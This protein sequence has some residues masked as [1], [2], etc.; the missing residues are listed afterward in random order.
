MTLSARLDDTI[1]RTR[2]LDHAYYRAWVAGELTEDD[3]RGYAKSYFAH[4]L[5]FPRYVSGVHSQCEDLDARRAL[6][7]NLVDEESGDEHH[8][9]LWLRF[10]EGLGESREAVEGC[11]DAATAK[12]IDTFL[13]RIRSSYAEGLGAL[14][15]YESQIPEIAETKV[16]SLSETY[17]ITDERTLAFFKVHAKADV[18]HSRTLREQIDGLTT[19]QGEQAEAAASECARGLWEFLSELERR[20]T[21]DEV[22][23]VPL[24]A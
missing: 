1:S 5:A 2:L 8:P 15:A 3:M 20:R 22:Q 14:Y 6:L 4:V 16:S 24:P 23:A 18:Y 10:A 19:E 11:R 17:D 9:E 13:G 12:L 21:A 7:D